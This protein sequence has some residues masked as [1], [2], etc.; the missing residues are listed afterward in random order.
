MAYL[1]CMNV[2]SSI[3]SGQLLLAE[4]FM[5]DPNFK[6]SVILLCEHVN[7]R[8][9]LGFI[10]NKP[11]RMQ[12]EDLI[13]DFPEFEGE[14]YYGG[15]VAT[16]TIHYVHNAGDLLEDSVEVVKGIYWGGDFEKLKFLIRSKL[17]TEK[18]IRFFVGYSG[19]SEGQL[20]EEMEFG[21]WVIADMD[22]NYL[23]YPKDKNL[24]QKVMEDKGENYSVIGQLPE[25]HRLN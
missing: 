12:V 13:G 22:P 11:L 1:R 2:D 17:I 7:D 24:W 3:I 14:A 15:P 23:F 18:D 20:Q 25:S 8:G 21:S 19:W 16:D 9:S 5:L 4:P 6:R 10:L